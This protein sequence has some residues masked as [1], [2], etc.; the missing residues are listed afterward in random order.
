M[1]RTTKY[2]PLLT[3]RFQVGDKV[4]ECVNVP[5]K[6]YRA[7]VVIEVRRIDVNEFEIFYRDLEGDV[8]VVDECNG[9]APYFEKI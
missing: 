8:S 2:S 4:R 6:A 3:S 7:G 5:M 1:T 9:Y